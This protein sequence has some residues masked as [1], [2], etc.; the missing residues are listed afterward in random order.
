MLFSGLRE[1]VA[2]IWALD[3]ETG[4]TQNL[5]ADEYYDTNPQVSPDGKTVVYAR[6]VS[7]N[8]KLYTFP[9]DDPKRKTQ[10]T[11]GPF[12]DDTPT[13]S[14]DGNV[15]YYS[16]T[17]DDDIYNLRSLDLRT[18]AVKQHSD[19]LGGNMA[20]AVLPGRGGD[21]LAF[22]SYLKGDYDLYTKDM[23]D[24][25][26]EIEQ[27]VRMAAEGQVDFVPDVVHQVVPENKRSKRKFEGLRLEGRPP[28]D[29]GVTSGGDFFGG[30]QVALT[31]IMQDHTFLLT[32]LSVRGYRVYEGQYINLSR[33]FQYGVQGFDRT[34]FF[35]PQYYIPTYSFSR[36]GV[37]ATQRYR[38]GLLIGQYPLDK[39]RRL[40]FS[41]GLVDIREQYEDP[42]YQQ[43]F[44]QQ[45]A[46]QR[47][48][49]LHEQRHL[50]AL[51]RAP[52]RGDHEVRPVRPPRRPDLLGR[53]RG[54]PAHRRACSRVTP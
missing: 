42:T 18:G 37:L 29:L 21:R 39:Q 13:F 27:D 22:I 45:A 11:F 7:G 41:G 14:P 26:R 53:R 23:A 47:A 34:Y 6:R 5:T 15:V 32:I 51:L 20:P 19:V 54:R 46:Q 36:D 31:D 10:L 12:D 2:D 9:L 30:T 25:T 43:Q 28:I 40:E 52:G 8:Y 16:S 17:E 48:E 3:L 35:Y 4:E 50:C 33:R 49:L 38:G 44:E 24:V 1:G